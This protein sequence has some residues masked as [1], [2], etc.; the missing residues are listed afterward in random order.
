MSRERRRRSSRKPAG[1]GDDASRELAREIPGGTAPSRATRSVRVHRRAPRLA[2]RRAGRSLRRAPRR[3]ARRQRVRR[4]RGRARRRRG[5]RRARR[6]ASRDGASRVLRVDDVPAGLAYAAAAV[7]GHPAFALDV[8]GIT[9]TNGKTTTTH[10]VR[11]AIDGAL[12]LPKCGIVGTLGHRYAGQTIAAVAHDARGR[13]ARARRS[14]SC[15]SAARRTSRWRSRRSRSCS[16]ACGPCASAWRRSRTSRRITSIFTARWR[17]TRPRR[18]RS[19]RPASPGLAVVNVDDP[20]GAKLAARR[21]SARC[22]ACARSVGASDADIAPVSRRR[23]RERHARSSRRSP[24]ATSRSRRASSV[25]HNLENL[26]V[27][28]G[29]RERA[30]PRRRRAPRRRSPRDRRARSPRALRRTRATTS[31]CSSTTRTRRTRSR[32]CSSRARVSSR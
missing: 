28:I 1:R 26:L 2:A 11:A 22:C 27:A 29:D 10:L 5:A 24:A 25:L 32:A 15:A 3:D 19:S 9:G 7:Y 21:A 20:F 13:R 23:E 14:R 12:G 6:R 8:I 17:P 31:S 16:V 18:R 4:R 30:R